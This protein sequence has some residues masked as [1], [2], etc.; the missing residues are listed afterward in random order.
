MTTLHYT[1]CHAWCHSR[2]KAKPTLV[3]LYLPSTLDDKLATDQDHH[4]LIAICPIGES[5]SRPVMQSGLGCSS[6]QPQVHSSEG[7]GH[8]RWS[9]NTLKFTFSYQGGREG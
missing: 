3:L 6:T 8:W 7:K 5:L 4:L 1:A 2:S 9:A